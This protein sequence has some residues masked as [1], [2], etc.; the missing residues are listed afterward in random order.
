MYNINIKPPIYDPEAVQPMRDELLYVGF[1][2]LTTPQLVEEFL[3][4][5]KNETVLVVI[6]LV[7]LLIYIKNYIIVILKLQ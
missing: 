1:K 2:E 5:K 4:P 6:N 3:T 7:I